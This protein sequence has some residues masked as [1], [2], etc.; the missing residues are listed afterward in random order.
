MATEWVPLFGDY[1]GPWLKTF[2]WLP[3][4]T[5]DAGWVW[6]SPVWK[7]H[8]HKHQYLYDGGSDYWWQYRKFAP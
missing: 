1:C 6:M 8:V 2:A 3:R 7:R 4:F 5:Y